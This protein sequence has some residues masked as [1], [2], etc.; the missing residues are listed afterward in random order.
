[1]SNIAEGF[2]RSSGKEFVQFLNIA[3]GSAAEV[4]A[5]LYVALDNG[6]IS[7]AQ[8]ETMYGM[9]NEIGAMLRTLITKINAH[10][11]LSTNN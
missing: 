8:F 10:I 5:Q 9:T 7:K 11:A 1:M 2:G 4:S 3:K 6:Y